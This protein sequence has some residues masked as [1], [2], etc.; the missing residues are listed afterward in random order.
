MNGEFTIEEGVASSPE[1]ITDDVD[2]KCAKDVIYTSFANNIAGRSSPAF[3]DTAPTMLVHDIG[4]AVEFATPP[5]IGELDLAA[6]H[7]DN[8]PLCLRHH[9]NVLGPS[10]PPILVDRG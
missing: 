3:D 8:A 2:I 4:Q 7:D 10:S 6:D 5:S 1:V 9:D